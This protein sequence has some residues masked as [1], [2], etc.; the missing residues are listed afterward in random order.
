MSYHGK[1]LIKQIKDQ[2]N[3]H[4]LELIYNELKYIKLCNR[5]EES[6]DIIC[7]LI[8]IIG[9]Y[10]ITSQKQ[11]KPEHFA[12]F[13]T[14]YSLDFM[15]EF[16]K[17][18]SYD[19]YKINL[20]LIKT[21]SFLLI[22]IKNKPTL[23]YLFSNNLLNKIISKDYTKYDDEFLSY[24]ANFLKSLSLIMDETSIQLFYI[25]KNNSFPL[26]ENILRLYNHKDSMIRNVVRNTVMTILRVKSTKIED[27]FSK[28][29]TILY[30]VKI[31]LRLRDIC[32]EIKEQIKKRNNKKIS[33]LFDD[34]LDEIIYIDDLLD[35]NMEKISYIIIN[36]FFNFFILPVLCA[37]ICEENQKLTKEQALF[38]LIFFLINIK[39]E[40]L[41][42][43]LFS[44]FFL[45]E[46]SPEIENLLQLEMDLNDFFINNININQEKNN[47]NNTNNN[48]INNINETKKK[49]DNISFYQFFSEHYSYY[50]LLTLIENNNII[51][52]KYGKIY[53]QL[54]KIMENGKELSQSINNGKINKNISPEEISKKVILLIEKFLDTDELNNMKNYHE[55]LSRGTGLVIGDLRKE[56][57]NNLKKID[58]EELIYEKCFMC[59]IRDFFQNNKKI[60]LKKNKIK[61]KLFDILNC[62]KEETLLLFNTL[63]F[64]VQNI[65]TN[66]SNYLLKI[67]KLTNIFDNIN[68]T[69]KNIGNKDIIINS[70]IPE[71]NN[72]ISILFDKNSFTFDN[73]FFT[74]LNNI[75]NSLNIQ[76]YNS[77]LLEQLSHLLNL[78]TPLWPIT[79]ELIYQ[80]IINLS[81]D[82]NYICNFDI[83][84]KFL[85]NIESKYKSVLFFINS[86]FNNKTKNADNYYDILYTQWSHYKNLNNKSLLNEIKDNV[87][88]SMEILMI[89]N[90][91]I[92]SDWYDSFEICTYTNLNNNNGKNI[93]LKSKKENICLDTK[94]LIL[95]L[96]KDLKYIFQNNNKNITDSLIKNKFP[97]NYYM[98]D[99]KIDN[100]YSVNSLENNK[101][102]KQFVYYKII[103]IRNKKEK[104]DFFQCEIF[105]YEKFLYFGNN[106]V[107]DNNINNI[108]IFKK[109]EI[110]LIYSYIDYSH[111]KDG[112]Y[113]VEL[114]VT[115]LNNELIIIKFQNN[116]QRKEFKDIIKE[117]IN[118]IYNNERKIFGEYLGNLIDEYKNEK[119][120]KEEKDTNIS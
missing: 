10:L 60:T 41:K 109:I 68:I 48:N 34:L 32:F 17:L 82:E 95:M 65:E 57:L 120:Q 99:L 46:I 13:D 7:S 45:D 16:L 117:K 31:I 1:K 88:S 63:L 106:C 38:L 51:Y 92:N 83:A 11:E 66:I 118:S 53:P 107:E 115:G 75:N 114:K 42:N 12:I 55:Y 87:I 37:S 24:Y 98:N 119:K 29:P 96:I 58:I 62:Q 77:G 40:N 25:E 103:D 8:N 116:Y 74:S 112:D 73:K 14:F 71:S 44:V 97:L 86:V 4:N 110:K 91:N 72:K 80:N 36:S 113:C 35:L 59:Y 49:E 84:D 3:S 50:F 39:N 64:V 102:Y 6:I 18:S 54:R 93:F 9:N 23:Y 52:T 56:N 15:S 69:T 67:T 30:F 20:E 5:I 108:Y 61:E 90:I 94:I 79:Y 26:V 70:I 27:Y 21:L 81:L 105:I 28:L 76:T 22:N 100:K 89:T 78:E 111:K 47:T 2:I 104:K 33:Y 101:L 85:K 43:C 19:Y